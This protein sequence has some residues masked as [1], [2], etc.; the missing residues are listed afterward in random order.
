VSSPKW[1]VEAVVGDVA[2]VISSVDV[3]EEPLAGRFESVIA[4]S[5][6]SACNRTAQAGVRW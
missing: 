5:T 3:E 1:P 6:L 2:P 4:S